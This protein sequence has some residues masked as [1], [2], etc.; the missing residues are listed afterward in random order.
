MNRNPNIQAVLDQMTQKEPGL[1][2]I[3][4]ASSH[5]YDC[6]CDICLQWWVSVGP[7]DTGNN[8]WGFGPFTEEEFVA[9]GGVVPPI[10]PDDW[11][12][13]FTDEQEDDAGL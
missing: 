5:N 2:P 12:G 9:A 3:L 8:T 13:P 6:R 4:E 11:V 1:I 10:G 7:E